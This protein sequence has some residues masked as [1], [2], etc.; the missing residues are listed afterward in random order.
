MAWPN[1]IC[2][3]LPW[4]KQLISKVF[5]HKAILEPPISHW[6]KSRFFLPV[7]DQFIKYTY[8]IPKEDGG[9]RIHMMWTDHPSWIGNWNGG[10]LMIKA[11][12]DPSIEFIVAQH[13]WL[14]NDCLFA[15]II[16][17]INTVMEEEDIMSSGLSGGA[18]ATVFHSEQAIPPIGES[19]SDYEAVGEVA[20]KLGMWEQYSGGKT[21]E[22]KI[23]HA[24]EN[25]GVAEMVS[26][27]ELNEKGYFVIPPRP[28]WEKAPAGLYN[29]YVD[30]EANPVHTK[31]GKIEFYSQWLAE[32]FPDDRERAPVP[33]WV[34]GG[35]GWSHDESLLSE[36][37]KMY[38]LLVISN[39]PRWRNHV[40]C[41]D[42]TW[43]WEIPTC[44]IRGSDGYMYEP[45][46]LHPTDAAE[47]DI[48]HGDIIKMFNE[49][50]TV[51]GAAYVIERVI[52]GA[53]MQDHGAG[54]MKFSPGRLKEGGTII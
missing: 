47:R 36:R 53:I 33:H 14:E 51:L 29:W 21:I 15:D 44:K 4:M 39:H 49:R 12:R 40:Q 28:D 23:Q 13:P 54:R 35:P 32:H 22:E 43:I 9:T 6:G 3:R 26:W 25:S 30:P 20:K 16:L 17:P 18:F 1:S 24:Y 27:E 5:I 38:P 11:W 7:E 34:Q 50:G 31:S 52:P 8:P 10:N 2:R 46:W 42:E 45:V 41:D 48:K 37:A 19:K